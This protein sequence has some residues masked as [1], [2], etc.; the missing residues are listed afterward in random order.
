M[1]LSLIAT[2]AF[3]GLFAL[4]LAVY[5]FTPRHVTV[6]RSAILDATPDVVLAL[7]GS[8]SGYQTFNP[9]KSTDPDLKIELFGPEKGIGSGFRFE[10]AEGKGSQ[11]VATIEHDKVH[12]KID[13]GAMGQPTQSIQAR[14][15][16]NGTEVIWSMNSDMGFNPIARV[17]GLFLDGMLG[18]TF[19]R[20]LENIE[21]AAA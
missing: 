5:L 6:V 3:A 7:A 16:Q 20:G 11:V 17:F 10:G 4:T 1:K 13:L 9:Y 18:K 2:Y 15:T 12:Y 21:K 19:E 14:Q 8:N